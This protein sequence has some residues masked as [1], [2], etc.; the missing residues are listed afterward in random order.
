MAQGKKQEKVCWVSSTQEIALC[1][2]V[3]SILIVLGIGG[4]G[5][6]YLDY[7]MTAS[8]Q[9]CPIPKIIRP[10]AFLQEFITWSIKNTTCTFCIRRGNFPLSDPSWTL[11]C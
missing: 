10:A 9:S 11:A 6:T 3:F 1:A 4:F 2:L 5:N 7:V 8:S